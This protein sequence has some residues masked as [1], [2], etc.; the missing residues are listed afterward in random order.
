MSK[1]ILQQINDWADQRGLLNIEWDKSAHASFIAE[2]LSEFLR[3]K[4]ESGEIDALCDIIV[5][6]ANAMRIRGYSPDVAMD[7]TLK[8]IN[9]RTG[10]FNPET[11]KWEKFKTEEA[12]ALWYSAAYEKAKLK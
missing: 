2:E 5:F 9:S 12:K 10:A 11:G 3:A 6:A 1:T 8:E 4:D 7:E